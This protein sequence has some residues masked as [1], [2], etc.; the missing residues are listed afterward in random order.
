MTNNIDALRI[1]IANALKDVEKD[2][3]VVIDL[4]VLKH[5]IEN[6]DIKVNGT[7]LGNRSKDEKLSNDFS[8]FVKARDYPQCAD[9]YGKEVL[10]NNRP[11]K[12]I[13]F[14]PRS[15]KNCIK[16]QCTTNNTEYVTSINVIADA[17]VVG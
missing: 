12:I 5:S 16:V 17:K 9:Y 13:G 6:F 11:M 7:F 3:N 2:H 15:P 14:K 1:S 8:N 10:L 4:G